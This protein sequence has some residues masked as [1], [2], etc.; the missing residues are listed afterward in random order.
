MRALIAE[1]EARLADPAALARVLPSASD[2]AETGFA[3][4]GGAPVE[5]AVLVPILL[6]EGAPSILLTLRSAR[7]SSHAG[8]VAFPGGRIEPGESAEAAAL[9]EAAEEVGLDPRLPRLLGR[10]PEHLTGT[11]YRVTP[12]VAVLTPPV[13]LTPDAGEVAEVFEYPLAALLDAR[14]PE[15]RRAEFRGRMREFWVWPH[16]RHLVW[17]ATAAILLNLARILRDE[18]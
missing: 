3:V 17:G 4:R 15:R 6:H 1:L 8:Q 18:G 2:D 9:R 16:E 12:V 10:L 7:L 5:A 11:G 14:A 13:T